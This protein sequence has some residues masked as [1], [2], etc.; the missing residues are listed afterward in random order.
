MKL[1]EK[2]VVVTGGSNGIG[3]QIIADFIGEGATVYNLDFIEPKEE[4]RT[5]LRFIK[6]D[7][8]D[9]N[10]IENAVEEIK[11]TSKAVDI[12]VNNACFSNKGLLSRCDFKAF[13][14]VLT[15]GITAPYLLT[16]GL[17]EIMPAG[18]SAIVNIASTR[19]LMSQADTESYSAA[20][21]GI[22]ALTHAMSMSLSGRVR[23]NAISPGWIDT[24]GSSFSGADC[25]QHPAGR[26]GRPE[27]ISR[28]VLFLVGEDA[29]FITGENIVI[30]GGMS[31][32]MIYHNDEG[33]EYKKPCHENNIQ[34][35]KIDT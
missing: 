16:M 35:N 21:G 13:N 2:T 27:D 33:W 30:D 31:K 3:K 25:S 28:M 20:K 8:R 11:K 10:Q 24:T 17:M 15:V 1:K 26:V 5:E 19:A 32:Q 14:D 18:K 23:V 12:L 9:A 34:N 29:N 6:C 22:V 7:L 4:N